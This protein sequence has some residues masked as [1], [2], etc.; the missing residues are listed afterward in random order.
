M[1][2]C[3]KKTNQLT[4]TEKERICSLFQE[5]FG[6]EKPLAKFNAQ[7]ERNAFGYSY[8]GLMLDEGRIVGCYSTIPFHYHYFG[9]IEVFAESV[10]TMIHPDYRGSSLNLKTMAESVYAALVNDGI[11]FVFGAPN[12]RIYPIRK[13]KL[14]WIDIAE[15]DFHILPIKIGSLK[16]S[17]RILDFASRSF[18]ILINAVCRGGETSTWIPTSPLP[19]E[20]ANGEEYASYRFQQYDK[21]QYKIILKNDGYFV[22]KVEAADGIKTG[23]LLDVFP[24]N[25]KNFQTAV[26][27]I[28]R[29][30]HATI[31]AI[32]YVG[33]LNFQP[34]NLY[35]V[36]IRQRP[37]KVRVTGRI[38]IADKVDKRIFEI[39]NWNLNLSNFDFA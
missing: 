6:C 17:F 15:L 31:D 23:L 22:Y 33:N 1:E 32:V 39:D 12:E 27:H 14:E 34:L 5:V 35:K 7:F 19:I 20:K 9:K 29:M 24:L 3:L 25:R 8:H 10:D 16:K 4:L 28:H 11:P 18:A 37:R 30:E 13:R 36:P 26:A 38:L 2:F 21:D